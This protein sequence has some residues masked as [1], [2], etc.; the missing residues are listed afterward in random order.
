MLRAARRGPRPRPARRRRGG[1]AGGESTAGTSVTTLAEGEG[2]VL[3]QVRARG[4]AAAAGQPHL[5]RV[6]GRG[7][8]ALAQARPCPTSRLGSQC[9]AK[10]A[11]DAVQAALRR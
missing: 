11:V 6:G 5:D 8:R 2:E 4:V 10:I 9:S 7:D 1:R 3:G